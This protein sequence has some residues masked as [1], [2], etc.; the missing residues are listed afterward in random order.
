MRAD[1]IF[2]LAR[3]MR[4]ATVGGPVRKA[5]AISSVVRP[6][7]SRSV[8]AT[9]ASGGRA[10]WQQVKTSRSRSS[11][12]TWSSRSAGSGA[13]RSSSRAASSPS[14]A[15]NLA[16]RRSRSIALKRPVEISQARGL[17]GMPSRGHC[18]IA[19]MKASWSASS[20]R[21]KS[22]SRRISVAR[23]RRDSER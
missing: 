23:T 5:L 6:Q 2:A 9:C 15:S 11:S 1:R 8:I 12:R 7:T 18:S 22:P 17:A 16:R 21:S 4:W 19:A 13:A 3:T 20:A 10:G 14:M